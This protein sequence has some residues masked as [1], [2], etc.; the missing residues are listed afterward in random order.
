[1]AQ[2]TILPVTN[3]AVALNSTC[4]LLMGNSD[5]YAIQAECTGAPSLQTTAD[6]FAHGCLMYQSDS[7]TGTNALY[8]N[9]GSIAVP[10]WTVID[11]GTGFSLPATVTDSTTT[12]GTSFD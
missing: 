6:V 2:N 9:T 3:Y 8:Q 1:M 10:A 5:M 4:N 12:I 7:G 11:T